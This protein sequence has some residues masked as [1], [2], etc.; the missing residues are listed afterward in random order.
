MSPIRVHKKCQPIR[1]SRLIGQRKNICKCFRDIT[2]CSSEVLFEVWDQG[3]KI[4]KS[5]TFLG[6]G[7]G[8][9]FIISKY[10]YKDNGIFATNS[11]FLIFLQLK[12]NVEGEVWNI[13]RLHHQIWVCSRHSISLKF[14]NFHVLFQY[15]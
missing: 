7:I 11:N 6:L 9:F 8:K 3:Q 5:D 14:C 4:G 15:Q 1:S 10:N 13:K 12:P 2:S